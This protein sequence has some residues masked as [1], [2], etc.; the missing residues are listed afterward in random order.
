MPIRVSPTEPNPT[1]HIAIRGRN[2][3]KVGLILCDEKG[4]PIKDIRAAFNKIPVDTTAQKQTSGASSYDQFEYPYSPIVQDD[5]SGGRGNPDFERDSTK[6]LDS[7]RARTSRANKAYAGPQE[8]FTSGLRSQDQNTPTSVTWHKLIG[9]QR[10]IYRRFQAS[11]SYTA[12]LAWLLVR[13]KSTPADLT[14]AIYEDDSGD[15]GTLASSITVEYTRLPDILSEWMNETISQVLSS[16]SYYWLVVYA[17]SSDSEDKHWMLG[18]KNATGTTYISESFDATPTAFT[19]DLYFRLTSANTEKTCIPFDYKEGKYFVISGT[20]GAPSLY[21]AGD[22]GTA[23][24]NTGELTKL[25]DGSK[26]WTVNEWAGTV[27]KIIDGPGSTEAQPWRVV[28]S[29]T[30]TEITFTEA[31]TIEHTTA[32]EYI[33]YGTKLTEITG[34]G[35][36]APVTDVLVTTRGIILFAQGDSTNIRR[37]KFETSGGAWT[38]SYAD[39][40]TNKATFL[41]YKPQAQKVVKTNNRDGSNDT[42]V[43]FADPVDWTTA[44][45]TFSAT[46]TKV[47]SKYIRITGTVVYPDENG[48]EALWVFKED[49]PY[50]VPGTG[51]PYPLTLEEM[52]TVRSEKNGRNPLVHGVYMYFPMGYGLERYYGGT[53]DDIGPNIGEGMPA[54]RRGA[55]GGMIGYPGRFFVYIDAGNAGYSSILDSGGWH[56]RYRAPLGQRIL[57]MSFQ[58]VPGSTPDRLWVYQ[59]ND[60]IILPFPSETT[61]ELEDSSYSFAPEFSVT[62]SRMHAGLFDVMKLIR[63]LKLQTENLETDEDT[64]EPVCW[65]ELDYRVNEETEWQQITQ[66]FDTSPTQEVDFIDEYG[67]AGKRLQFRIRGY[68]TDNTKTP[69]LLAVVVNAVL[70]VDVKYMYGPFNFRCMDYEPLLSYGEVDDIQTAVEKQQAIENYADASSDSMLYTESI[71]DLFHKRVLFM[72]TPNF[73]QVLLKDDP[74]NKYKKN[75]MIGTVSFQEA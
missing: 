53:I 12:A 43:A 58:V 29:N 40:G 3:K 2:G 51:N 23:D 4:D 55:I 57:A 27:V 59:G 8:Q 39:D 20:T 48:D 32:T 24:S 73:R 13:R 35:L 33:L 64:G 28:A 36:T 10:Y 21:I 74:T 44:S 14:I 69:V 75:I 61:N 41:D 11:A 49:L 19:K 34:H 17:D 60:L 70:R 67:L 26:N 71:A 38:P 5:W 72:N 63:K 46:P 6:F 7:F 18:M 42:S 31:W 56:E 9:S 54:E 1:H 16:G 50:I 62:L 22:R 30:A 68:T 47:D 66:R 52:R 45:H 65:F 37:A 15:V 25:K